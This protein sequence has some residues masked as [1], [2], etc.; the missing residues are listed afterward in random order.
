MT[1][2][3][4]CKWFKMSLV[5]IRLAGMLYVRFPLWLRTVEDLPHER[6]VDVSHEAVRIWWHRPFRR[7]EGAMLRFRRMRRQQKS[8]SFHASIDNLFN[9]ESSHHPRA[10]FKRNRA[11]ALAEWRDLCAG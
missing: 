11:A 9:T 6:G 7:R 10:S 2:P 1:K 3:G 4:S 8:A 5:I